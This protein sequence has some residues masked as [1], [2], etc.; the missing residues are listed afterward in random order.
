[1]RQL[2]AL[3]TIVLW[4]FAGLPGQISAA[5]VTGG[6]LV[7]PEDT[8]T[9]RVLDIE[10]FSPQNLAPIRVD[11][12]G[13]IRLPILGRIHVAGQNVEQIE[14][15]IT[16]GLLSIMKAPEVTVAVTRYGSRPIS[17]LGAVRNP[18]VRQ[19]SGRQTLIEAISLAGGL[20][21]E[22]G[23]SIIITR[24]VDS[25]PLPLSDSSIDSSGKFIVGGLKVRAVMQANNPSANIEVMANDVITVPKADLIYVI[26][27]VKKPGGFILNEKEH[28]SALQALSLAE[29]LD[30]LAGAKSARIL[31]QTEE[32]SPRSDIPVNLRSMLDGTAPDLVLRANDIL[33]V[34]GNTAKY[35][36]LRALEVA[37][38]MGVGAAIWR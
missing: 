30:S 16:K 5:A 9:V 32:G 4:L 36:T 21:A 14:D 22:A 19:I 11:N 26:G 34:P 33:F 15:V 31:R 8:V 23:N 10:E 2:T 28:L 6:Y 35:V 7:G 17:V 24:R 20:N 27:A 12:Q 3:F 13:D 29:G 18:G 25:G 38:Q 1:M 37:I